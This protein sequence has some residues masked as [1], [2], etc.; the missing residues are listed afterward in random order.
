MDFVVAD[1]GQVG[2]A[3]VLGIAIYVGV[4]SPANIRKAGACTGSIAS[5]VNPLPQGHGAC[6]AAVQ[7]YFLLPGG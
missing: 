1:T 5:R 6:K 2:D 7:R 3:V 4:R